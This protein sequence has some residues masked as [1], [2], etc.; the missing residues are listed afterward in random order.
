MR[1]SRWCRWSW[2]WSRSGARE[3]EHWAVPE[4]P[5]EIARFGFMEWARGAAVIALQHLLESSIGPA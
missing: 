4:V 3:I 1:A 2:T 5:I